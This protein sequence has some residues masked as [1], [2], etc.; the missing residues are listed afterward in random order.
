M[1][2]NWGVPDLIMKNEGCQKRHEV[3]LKNYVILSVSTDFI[4]VDNLFHR[5]MLH[6]L[7]AS[8]PSLSLQSLPISQPKGHPYLVTWST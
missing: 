6:K 7:I 1:K 3:C 5:I 8:Y 2:I 4:N